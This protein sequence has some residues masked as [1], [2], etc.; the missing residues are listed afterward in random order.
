MICIDVLTSKCLTVQPD[1]LKGRVVCG[2]VYGDIHSWIIRKSG[3][4]YPGPG[5]L[6][7][8]TWP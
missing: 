8:A 6:C 7:S 1:C 4:L 3:V 5:F 2:T